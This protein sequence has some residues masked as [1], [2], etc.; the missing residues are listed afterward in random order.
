LLKNTNFCVQ[1]PTVAGVALPGAALRTAAFRGHV[2][3][4]QRLRRWA[5]EEEITAAA[6][7]AAAAG[8]AMG[9]SIH[10]DPSPPMTWIHRISLWPTFFMYS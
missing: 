4:L 9:I 1:L 5:E 3:I 10:A 7:A 6:L 2:A 8:Q